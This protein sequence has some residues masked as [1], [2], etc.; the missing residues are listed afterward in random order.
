MDEEN[1]KNPFETARS[2][3]NFFYLAVGGSVLLI[4][5]YLVYTIGLFNLFYMLFFIWLAFYILYARS[6]VESIKARR[7]R[8][9]KVRH[10][11]AIALIRAPMTVVNLLFLFLFFNKIRIPYILWGFVLLAWSI[12]PAYKLVDYLERKKCS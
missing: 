3:L 11:F 12:F 5:F 8:W 6:F 7:G 1:K 10:D 2:V 9:S 4:L